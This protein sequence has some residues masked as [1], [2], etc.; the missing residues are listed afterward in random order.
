MTEGFTRRGLVEF[1]RGAGLAVR[2]TYEKQAQGGSGTQ[3][4][5][6]TQLLL[7]VIKI[8]EPSNKWIQL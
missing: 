7:F 1:Y 4:R 3:H 2:G 6:S 8:L 5:D